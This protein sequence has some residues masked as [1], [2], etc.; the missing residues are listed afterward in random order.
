[1]NRALT[2]EAGEITPSL[3]IRRAEI[4]KNFGTLIDAMYT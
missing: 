4:S 1:L 2:I 3:K